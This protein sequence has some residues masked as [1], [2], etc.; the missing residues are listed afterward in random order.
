MDS[1]SLKGKKLKDVLALS[2]PLQCHPEER[3]FF[4]RDV[5]ISAGKCIVFWPRSS[6][7]LR[8]LR[9]TIEKKLLLD[10]GVLD[11]FFQHLFE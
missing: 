10:E 4:E 1:L 5:R 8:P 2:H 11:L 9:M 6:R 3:S 7:G